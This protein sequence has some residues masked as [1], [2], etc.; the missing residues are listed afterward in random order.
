[1]PQDIQQKKGEHAEGLRKGEVDLEPEQ[2]VL[3]LP[4]A[5]DEERNRDEKQDPGPG[6]DTVSKG[7]QKDD[8]SDEK[9]TLYKVHLGY[10]VVLRDA[11]QQELSG[12]GKEHPMLVVLDP[13]V[14]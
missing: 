4:E 9:A 1:M 10:V 8:Q 5:K 14:R 6:S 13:K 7:E 11:T 3:V 12:L 2:H